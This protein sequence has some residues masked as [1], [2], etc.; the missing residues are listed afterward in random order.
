LASARAQA[1]TPTPPTVETPGAPPAPTI[2]PWTC[3]LP[4]SGC[5]V[6]CAEPSPTPTSVWSR[7]APFPTWTPSGA[8]RTPTVTVTPTPTPAVTPTPTPV[9]VWRV[10]VWN[11]IEANRHG[12]FRFGATEYDFYV[13]SLDDVEVYGSFNVDA[14]YPDEAGKGTIF[15]D[16]IYVGT[17]ITP[18]QGITLTVG[19][20]P[21]D[22]QRFAM[23]APVTA[24]DGLGEFW[25][26][27]A[28]DGSFRL[29]HYWRTFVFNYPPASGA[30]VASLSYEA[31][32]AIVSGWYYFKV[33]T[34]PAQVPLATPTPTP[35]VT[36]TP[37]PTPDPALP[38]W[39]VRFDAPAG[40]S[41][42]LGDTPMPCSPDWVAVSPGVVALS[43]QGAGSGAIWV[44]NGALVDKNVSV[45]ASLGGDAPSVCI[46]GGCY[47]ASSFG[48]WS[49]HVPAGS[50]IRAVYVS[51]AGAAGSEVANAFV[52]L[53]GGGGGGGGGGPS[54]TPTPFAW[55]G[56]DN[57]PP[58]CRC[59]FEP[60]RIVPVPSISCLWFPP[61]V[62][63]SAI[64]LGR[65]PALRVC[66]QKYSISLPQLDF[67]L[68]RAGLPIRSSDFLNM[69][70][71]AAG[72]YIA[73]RLVR[74]G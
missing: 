41:C 34:G 8:T 68:D 44:E 54:P 13:S 3:G 20:G 53:G 9:P 66:F 61:S 45:R 56:C 38:R 25:S 64:G 69:L 35:A 48:P 40:A 63:L 42:R 47:P 70:T 30:T 11:R 57:L 27:G 32:N 58:G 67:M 55:P 23:W 39:R 2:S 18:S 37:T 46:P 24:G 12:Q 21:Y 1:P 19:T 22:Y 17:A 74:R 50:Q 4:G 33:S 10:R 5:R 31:N 43:F 7:W 72:F 73:I 36:P 26:Y 60:P 29:R 6:V 71:V 16:V 14:S 28:L 52:D 15:L 65:T 62:D 49:V 59:V 51:Q